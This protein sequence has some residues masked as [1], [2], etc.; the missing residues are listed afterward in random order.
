MEIVK[1]VNVWL[2]IGSRTLPFRTLVMKPGVFHLH[3][4]Q[5]RFILHI[6]VN[7]QV[8]I[9]TDRVFIF[10]A[11]LPES[12]DGWFDGVQGAQGWFGIDW[13]LTIVYLST[14]T[15][16]KQK[17]TQSCWSLVPSMHKTYPGLK[18]P[19]FLPSHIA[20][21][22]LRNFIVSDWYSWFIVIVMLPL[23]TWQFRRESWFFPSL[24]S[25]LNTWFLTDANSHTIKCNLGTLW[26]HPVVRWLLDCPPSLQ[27]GSHSGSST[28]P[29]LVGAGYVQAQLW[30]SWSIGICY[31]NLLAHASSTTPR[32]WQWDQE[33]GLRWRTR[34]L[35]AVWKASVNRQSCQ[36]GSRWLGNHAKGQG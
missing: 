4:A 28:W 24:S 26:L 34:F 17:L 3:V 13:G 14:T 2:K 11:S 1:L 25:N 15:E 5:A 27:P 16:Y 10:F 29:T 6:R 12:W 19:F 31:G 36:A 9:Q 8:F 22:A 21:E 30:G 35:K 7:G 32:Q 20:L 23:E 33:A 18:L